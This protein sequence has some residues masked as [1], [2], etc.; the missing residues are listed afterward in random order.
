[1]GGA[2][3]GALLGFT[4]YVIYLEKNNSSR[5]SEKKLSQEDKANDR[6][7]HLNV[8]RHQAHMHMNIPLA[9]T[10]KKEITN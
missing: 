3:T 5:F 9:S 7:E 2:E 6:V 8:H 10:R 1:M 4:G